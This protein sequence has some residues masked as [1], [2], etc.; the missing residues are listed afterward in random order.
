MYPR[1]NFEYANLQAAKVQ[2]PVGA[3]LLPRGPGGRRQYG[4]TTAYGIAEG[5]K[6]KEASWE[7]LK[8]LVADAGQQHLVN[9]ES[10]TPATRKV[11]QSPD[12]PAEVWKVFTDA[13][14]DAQYF[15]A[16]PNFP[17]VI[18]AVNKELGE[19]LV[20]DTRSVRDSARA[21]AEAANRLIGA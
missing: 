13:I 18:E 1:G 9:T 17:A 16:L 20:T 12:V 4:Q 8:W 3:A 11:Y 15:P 6:A 7:F 5:S 10:I 14:K 2:F 21:A 19:A